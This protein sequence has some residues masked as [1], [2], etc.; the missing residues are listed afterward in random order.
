MQEWVNN[1]VSH[2]HSS[3]SSEDAPSPQDFEERMHRIWGTNTTPAMQTLEC[4]QKV[5][6]A[7]SQQEEEDTMSG[8]TFGILVAASLVVVLGIVVVWELFLRPR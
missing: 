5:K 3:R 7:L 4:I 2:R 1:K 6:A 8:A